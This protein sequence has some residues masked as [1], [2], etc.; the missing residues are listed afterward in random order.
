MTEERLQKFENL[1]DE[2]HIDTLEYEYS[3]LFERYRGYPLLHPIPF[4]REGER[5][6]NEVATQEL[7]REKLIEFHEL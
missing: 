7:V 1:L 4:N 6:N 3:Y 5:K 2:I